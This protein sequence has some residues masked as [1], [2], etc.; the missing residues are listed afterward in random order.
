MTEHRQ[1]CMEA[2][3]KMERAINRFIRE[4]EKEKKKLK[5]SD[6]RYRNYTN[7]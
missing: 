1:N 5:E 4:V 6:S 7:E 3:E 2:K